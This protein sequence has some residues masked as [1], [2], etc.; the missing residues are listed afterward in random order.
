LLISLPPGRTLEETRAALVAAGASV[1]AAA[2]VGGHAN[3]YTV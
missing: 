1:R 2:L 3:R